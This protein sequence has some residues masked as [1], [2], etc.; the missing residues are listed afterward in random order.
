[1]GARDAT[2]HSCNH[3]PKRRPRGAPL[4]HEPKAVTYAREKA[5]LT[6][7]A[8]AEACGFSEQLLCDIEAGRRNAIPSKLQDIAAVLNCPLVV[9]EAKRE[10]DGPAGMRPVL[11]G[12]VLNSP[13]QDGPSAPTA[14]DVRAGS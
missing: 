1:M 7:R 14:G 2:S 13:T 3:Q 8:L 6:K 5:G 12:S 4:N 11:G 9:L 10:V